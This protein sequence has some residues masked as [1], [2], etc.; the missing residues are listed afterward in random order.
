MR[1]YL[2]ALDPAVAPPR[3]MLHSYGGSPEMV[4][5]FTSIG[6]GG[7]GSVGARVFFSFSA[8]LCRRGAKK[9]AARVRAVPPA[10]LLLESDLTEVAPIDAALA[11]IVA[12]VGDAAEREEGEVVRQAAANFEAF[13]GMPWSAP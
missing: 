13:Y 11:D 9:A 10:R 4:R 5:E 2:R 12:F 6:G 7:P 8:V 1:D 3:I